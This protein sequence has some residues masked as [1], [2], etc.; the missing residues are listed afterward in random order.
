MKI[1]LGLAAA[2]YLSII[3]APTEARSDGGQP[4][5]QREPLVSLLSQISAPIRLNQ[6]PDTAI[7]YLRN[8]DMFEPARANLKPEALKKI[9]QIGTVLAQYP[10]R[11]IKIEGFSDNIGSSDFNEQLSQN[12]AESV[13]EV[14]LAKQ[15]KPEQVTIQGYGPSHPIASN[16]TEKGRALNRRIEIHILNENGKNG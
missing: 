7:I 2:L 4:A 15:V 6:G 9:S 5:T 1:Q 8:E 11:K 10:H 14:L 12:R 3:A 16:S 13:K